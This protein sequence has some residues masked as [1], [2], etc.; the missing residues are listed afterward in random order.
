MK[1]VSSRKQ[2][3]RSILSRKNRSKN[4]YDPHQGQQEKARRK[5]RGW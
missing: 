5:E 2:Q 3:K 4:K 1:K